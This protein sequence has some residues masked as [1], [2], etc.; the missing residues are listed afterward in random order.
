MF[1]TMFNGSLPES[2][3][4]PIVVPDIDPDT[5]K[6]LCLYVYGSLLKVDT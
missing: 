2:T 6:Q 4:K 3:N 5:F 1:H